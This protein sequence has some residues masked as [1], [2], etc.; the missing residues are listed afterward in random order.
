MIHHHGAWRAMLFALAIALQVVATASAAAATDGA[1]VRRIDPPH[2]WVGMHEPTVQLMVY[3]EGIAAHSVRSASA[4]VR[5]TR[6]QR[7][8]SPNYLFVDLHIDR[9]RKAGP[10]DLVFTRKGRTFRHRYALLARAPGSAQ[11][12]GFGNTDVILNLMPDRFANGDPGNDDIG[13]YADKADRRNGNGRHGGDLAGITAHLDDIAALGYTAIWPTPA[14]ENAQPNYSYHG[15]SATDH[16]RVDPRFGGNAAWMAL[17]AAARQRGICLVQDIVLNHIGSGHWWLRDLPSPDWL[18]FDGRFTPTVHARTTALDPYAAQ[19]DRENFT[20]GW[21]I[22]DMPDLNQ[23]NPLVANYLMQHTLWW[24]EASGLCGL[25]VDTWGY[26]E[27]AFLG[28]WTR[29]V[30]KE[31]PRLNIVAEE[32]SEMPAV[33][34]NWL[35]DRPPHGTGVPSAMDFPLRRALIR[36]LTEPDAYF[37]GLPALFE[38][39]ANDTLYPKPQNLVL[40][41]GNHDVPRIFSALGGDL[42]LWKMAMVYLATAHRIPQFYYGTDLLMT[43]PTERNDPEFRHD[44]PGGW[45]GDAVNGFTGAGLTDAQREAQAFLRRLLQWRKTQPAIHHGRFL[46]Y[47]PLDSTYVYF[48]SHGKQRVMVVFNKRTEAARLDIQRFAE[49]LGDARSARDVLS[50]A[51]FDIR[52][53]GIEVPARTALVLTLDD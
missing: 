15:Y 28:Q 33:V 13:G 44:Y 18:T 30:R 25:R 37:T 22:P 3:G 16:Y 27:H 19:L 24:I 35:H 14:L 39:M 23:K 50:G 1:L 51:T 7:V 38:A 6:M 31:Y 2:W 8:A 17:A 10:V 42:A 43:S 53:G 21:F 11:R 5:V 26:S 9:K 4:G 41:E 52:H 32:W 40:F 46:H 34:S 49:G 12:R 47:A 48:R 36:G 45:P 20:R 29:R